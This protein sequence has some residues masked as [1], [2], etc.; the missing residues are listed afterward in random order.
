MIARTFENRSGRII[1]LCRAVLALVFFVALWIDPAQ[2]VRS[3]E[4]GYALLGGYLL[5][6]AIMLGIA[7][8]GWWIEQTIR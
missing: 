5:F 6:G 2:P 8:S 4:L 1:A 7:M 3:S